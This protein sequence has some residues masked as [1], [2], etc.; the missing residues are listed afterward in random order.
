MKRSVFFRA[1]C[2]LLAWTLPLAA[3]VSPPETIF[4]HV[5][6]AEWTAVYE[7]INEELPRTAVERLQPL[8]TAARAEEQWAEAAKAMA[9]RFLQEARYEESGSAGAI[10]KLAAAF[11]E[12]PEPLRTVLHLLLADWYWGYYEQ[13]RWR[14]SQRE[15]LT[16]GDD[17]DLRTW[18]IQRLFETV[19]MHLTGALGDPALL[20]SIAL[21]E[22]AFILNS[23]SRIDRRYTTLYDFAI[24]TATNFYQA[25][26]Q[27]A[28]RMEDPFVLS[29]DGPVLAEVGRFLEWTGP[30]E[31]KDR[32]FLARALVLFQEA[33]T[34]H[35][36]A[37]RE[38]AW[39]FLNLERLRL[40][41][42]QAIG[43]EVNR[44]YTESLEN[45]LGSVED[46]GLRAA[47]YLALAL[48]AQEE[49][50]LERA[51]ARATEAMQA[52]PRSYEG[53]SAFN[54]IAQLEMKQLQVEVESI[55]N[56][57]WPQIHLRHRHLENVYFK[58]LPL[59]ERQAL[60]YLTHAHN[61]HDLS[62]L[63]RV[64]PVLEWASDLPPTGDFQPRETALALPDL[65]AP[66]TYLL[67]TSSTPDFQQTGGEQT[68][69]HVVTISDL[70]VVLRPSIHPE[71]FDGLVMDALTGEPRSGVAVK[72]YQR[73]EHR[74]P[75][76]VVAE[77]STNEDGRFTFTERLGSV[78]LRVQGRN[79]AL[80]IPNLHGHADYRNIERSFRRVHFFTD[81]AIYRPGQTIH[82]QGIASHH[83]GV[84]GKAYSLIAGQEV[85]VELRDVNQ[86][87]VARQVHRT[88]DFGSFSGTFTAPVG[89]LTGRMSIVAA[90]MSGQVHF[91]VEEYQR[92][93]FRVALDP[94]PPGVSLG[95][96]I[97]LTGE[98]KT[99]TGAPVDGGTYQWRVERETH[100]PPWRWWSWGDH[101]RQAQP[102]ARGQGTTD[103]NGQ[104]TLDFTAHPDGKI[105]PDDDPAFTFRV[106]V[107][108]T[109]QSGETRW[110]SS[111]ITLAYTTLQARLESAEWSRSDRPIPVL[112]RTRTHDGE[113]VTTEGRLEIFPV[114]Q[115]ERVVR[116]P[117]RQRTHDHYYE[118]GEPAS[119]PPFFQW[120]NET[121]EGPVHAADI[122][123][124]TNGSWRSEIHLDPGL[125][126]IE[127]TV[128]DQRENSVR[129]EHLLTVLDPEDTRFP[130]RLP[131][132]L[133]L[134]ST[135][136][137]PGETL[138]AYWGTGY[139][140][141]R[142]LVEIIREETV[143]QRYWTEGD[144][145]LERIHFPVTD[146]LRGGFVLRVTTV[147]ENR[148]TEHR[149]R[150]EVPWTNKD[151]R[152]QWEV[153]R[154]EL[155]PGQDETW[156]LRVEG[157]D[158]KAVKAE[159]VA[160]LY[161]ASLDALRPHAWTDPFI[162]FGQQRYWPRAAGFSNQTPPPSLHVGSF[163]RRYENP[164]RPW[165]PEFLDQIRLQ[166]HSRFAFRAR[167]AGAE[168]VLS[169]PGRMEVAGD[170][171]AAPM[172]S[173]AAG[174]VAEE[175]APDGTQS[176]PAPPTATVSPDAVPV[177]TNLQETAFFFPQLHS[178]DAGVVEL[179]WTMPEALTE[180]RFMGFAFDRDLRRGFVEANAVTS[181]DLMVR[182]LG[183]RFI[184]EG[185]TLSF[186]VQVFNRS[187]TGQKAF[188]RL[189]FY[190]ARTMDPVEGLAEGPETVDVTVP[191]G[192]S[193]TVFW[194]VT[195]PDGTEFLIYRAVAGNDDMSDGEEGFLPVLPRQILI[196]ES[197]PLPLRGAG[198]SQREFASLAASGE[199][200]TLRHER[201][202]VQMVSQPAWYALLALPTLMEFPHECAEQ[203]FNRWYAHQ[204]G[205]HVVQS[206]PRIERVFRLWRETGAEALTSPLEKNEE[207]KNVT[208]Q[209][210][211]WV[212]QG[213]NETA[214]RARVGRLFEQNQLRHESV[215][216]L[217]RLSE[218]QRPDGF[219]PWFSGGRPNEF[220]TLYIATGMGRLRHLGVTDIDEPM[221]HRAWRALDRWM[222]ERYAE[223]RRRGVLEQNNLSH[224]A[225]L[226]LYGRSFFLEDLP[227]NDGHW[228]SVRYWLQQ[229][230]TYA[231]RNASRQTQAHAALALHRF[232]AHPRWAF[233]DREVPAGILRSIRE[234]A[235]ESEELGLYW[236][237]SRYTWWWHQAPIETQAILIE[238]FGEVMAD[239]DTVEGARIWLLRQKQVQD[240]RTTKATADAVYAL[241]LGGPDWLSSDAVVQVS[242]GDRALDPGAVEPGTGYFAVTIPGNEVS[243]QMAEITLEKSDEGVS[244]GS[245]HWQY[246]EDLDRIEAAPG[247]A[248]SVAK[249]LF[250]RETGPSGPV[251]R[252][253]ADQ[254]L[255]VGDRLV[256]RLILRA[257][258]DM[259]F[260][261]LKDERGSGVEPVNVL[262]GY[263]HQDGLWYYEST[264][265]TA[266]HFFIEYLPRGT[267][268]FT[269]DVHVRHA[270]SF[271]SGRATIQSMYAPEFNSHSAGQRL[272]VETREE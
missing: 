103:E 118:F 215:R 108:V 64:Q 260:L 110:T 172:D 6:Q 144:R 65:P 204:I 28:R 99:Y 117:L 195:I 74:R 123:T 55:W 181:R 235:V 98:A 15:D 194:P 161:D 101:S 127:L 5:R 233:L 256:S 53:V 51:H 244:W 50:D 43:P 85:R 91:S 166:Q 37:G 203:T 180:W 246:F 133:H 152:V 147:Q 106:E 225:G 226:Y 46:P 262:S 56:P 67:L 201:L 155:L 69:G 8:F 63:P 114:Q 121:R 2:F 202:Q 1:F 95:Q 76:R 230:E 135:R 130:V 257:D 157:P 270:G 259:E 41:K 32:S 9:L 145:S 89:V 171:V 186:P 31:N 71:T 97:R 159:F 160:T 185:D 228:N 237:T 115:P 49:G 271:L 217:A 3:Q 272:Q 11:P 19:D 142:A 243:P 48:V 182:P 16:A 213:Q 174:A 82:Y 57:P 218:Q 192:Q 84:P 269:T 205:R 29:A 38:T 258:R 229:A 248:L 178:D 156:T 266:S 119:P 81:R 199:S 188:V 86:Q 21:P 234:N 206:N 27:A 227:V 151:L 165:P 236:P 216:A 138:Q 112:A 129:T 141:G 146:D 167:H 72:A 102:I 23:A 170:M 193:R 105:S 231:L 60:D 87:V 88:N 211:P 131:S 264:L 221:A 207:L 59:T 136:L 92:P 113:P 47:I 45:F 54:L 252:P 150:I 128:P 197:L 239:E 223:L 25:G 249:E 222:D 209:E 52:A 173:F 163:G 94:A 61:R 14:F 153:F 250:V 4:N 139:A 263:R 164:P 93:R 254:P 220:I 125:Y 68:F 70:A 253:V 7:A 183:P 149:E 90:T 17:D 267:Y 190:D 132:A 107:E 122:T 168:G 224:L 189:R 79:N 210:T 62:T 247:S 66:G 35:R 58:L 143:L 251:L 77:T 162:F 104:F 238:A 177:R 148:L 232:S 261:H 34:Y 124:D 20:Q 80:L 200:P 40:G 44:F 214:R 42:N 198:V 83:Q 208:L 10:E 30:T 175:A 184:R 78:V 22:I 240:W 120:P 245:V 255:R 140:R 12:Q 179:R 176:P 137:E 26:E 73:P 265:D 158:A 111:R 242:L 24:R 241:L 96:S 36:E 33:I 75:F 134:E 100:F 187:E 169:S 39:G 154:S 212:R 126:R 196:T 18:S 191:A 13:N 109:D 219:W 116:E 268:V